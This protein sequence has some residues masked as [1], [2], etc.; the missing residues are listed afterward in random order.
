MIARCYNPHNNRYSYYGGRGV[1][2]CSRWRESFEA[3]LADMGARPDGMTLDRFPDK[4]GNYEPGNVRWATPSEQGSNKRNNN[5]LEYDGQSLT[6]SEWAR[7]IGIT[8]QAIRQRLRR[9][10][11]VAEALSPERV[12]R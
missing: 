6:I 11:S 3:F 5:I 12:T 2:V 1:T 4:G 9:G 10:L 7:K 8:H